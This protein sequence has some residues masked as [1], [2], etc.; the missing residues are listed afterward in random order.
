MEQWIGWCAVGALFFTMTGQAWKQW[1]DRVKTGIG[2]Y[3][4]VG[5]VMA[6][7]CF[8]AY[9]ILKGDT[10]FIVGNALVLAAAIS[11]GIILFVNRRYR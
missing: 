3:F 7:V 4:F 6:S 9:S 1:R 5:Q 8:L 2:K 10:V 11:G